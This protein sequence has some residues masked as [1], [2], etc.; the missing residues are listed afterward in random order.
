MKK[1]FLPVAFESC[2]K[3]ISRISNSRPVRSA[4]PVILHFVPSK[5]GSL[6]QHPDVVDTLRVMLRE[7]EISMRTTAHAEAF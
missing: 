3:T 2:A 4:D 7:N 6:W 5:F 1:I